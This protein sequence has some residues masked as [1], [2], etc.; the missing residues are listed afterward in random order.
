MTENFW[1]YRSFKEQGLDIIP[2]IHL[3]EK[4]S[5]LE[6]AGIQSIRGNINREIRKQNAIILQAKATYTQ[7][8]KSLASAKLFSAMAIRKVKNEI[9]DMIQEVSK[10]NHDRLKLPVLGTKYLRQVTDRA[11]LQSRERM[12]QF[13]HEHELTSFDTLKEYKLT[14]EQKYNE[15]QSKREYVSDRMQ[16]L[17]AL[18]YL[19]ESYEPFIKYH[20]EQWE[21]KGFA[22]KAY[23]RK[24][25][26]E[27]ESYDLYRNKIKQSI[28]EPDKKITPKA[29]KKE[30]TQLE[31][32]LDE[33]REPFGEVIVNLS[34]IELLEYNKKELGRMMENEKHQ[35]ELSINQSRKKT[36]QSL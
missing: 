22:R 33:I 8:K 21:L 34:S 19:Y 29:W 36:E 11:T 15:M 31:K 1:E 18:L 12:E 16:Y 5:A 9:I 3:G 20:K 28:V 35:K 4:A 7:A 27:L 26:Y 24:H 17:E 32:K 6:K 2:E 10:R 30:L 13:V 25:I 14:N 23:E